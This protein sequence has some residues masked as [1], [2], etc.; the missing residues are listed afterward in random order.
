[1]TEQPTGPLDRRDE[2]ALREADGVEAVYV[3]DSRWWQNASFAL[4]LLASL[5]SLAV[6]V[7]FGK[8]EAVGFGMF[9][10]AVT[11]IMVPVVLLTWRSTATAI[12][13]TDEG[14]IAL[15]HGRVLHALLWA[16]LR[17]IERV[18]YLGNVRHKLVHAR[19]EFLTVESEI[20]GAAD[21]VDRAFA[22]SGLP[23]ASEREP[24][25]G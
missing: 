16:D 13:L 4:P 5:L 18:E 14:A 19:D 8:A 24:A 22:L 21:L 23:R 11:I 1:M 17:R 9:L 20:A 15:H 12:A 25:G 7:I 2:A 10:A 6:G 3:N